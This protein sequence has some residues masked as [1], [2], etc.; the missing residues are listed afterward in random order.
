MRPEQYPAF[1]RKPLERALVTGGSGFTGCNFLRMMVPERLETE[2][3]NLDA[4]TYT[5]L[6]PEWEPFDEN[7]RR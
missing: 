6:V 2:R 3:V 1:G 5:E 4:L 7:G